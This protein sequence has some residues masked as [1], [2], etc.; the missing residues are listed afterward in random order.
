MLVGFCVSRR[1]RF[2]CDVDRKA[3]DTEPQSAK[4]PRGI[5]PLSKDNFHLN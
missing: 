2:P 1:A 5:V 4:L 3:E